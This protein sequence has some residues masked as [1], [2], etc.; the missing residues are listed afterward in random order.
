MA[1]FVPRNVTYPPL[2]VGGEGGGQETEEFKIHHLIILVLYNFL[3]PFRF[4]IVKSKHL[5][6]LLTDSNI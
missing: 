1:N 3:S 4:F 2:C 5:N 6:R